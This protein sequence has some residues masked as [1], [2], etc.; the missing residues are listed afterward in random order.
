ML[1]GLPVVASDIA[2]NRDLVQQDKTG[3]LV[4]LGDRAAI[5]QATNLLL[6]DPTRAKRLGDAARQAMLTDFSVENMVR[7]HAELYRRLL[8]AV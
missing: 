7:R 8:G 5:A 4:P 6:D 2:G 1:A 3:V